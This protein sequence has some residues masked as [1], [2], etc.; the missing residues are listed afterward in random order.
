M[1][2]AIFCVIGGL[3]VFGIGALRA[4]DDSLGTPTTATIHHCVPHVVEEL[5]K[6][7][8]PSRS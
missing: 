2:F 4:Y 1:V 6:G 5:G 7:P 8:P 3:N